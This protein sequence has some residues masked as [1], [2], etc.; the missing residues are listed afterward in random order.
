MHFF[1]S[2]NSEKS[3]QDE[4]ERFIK[5]NEFKVTQFELL[6]IFIFKSVGFKI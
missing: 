5:G 6:S 2:L 3:S 4:K 1:K